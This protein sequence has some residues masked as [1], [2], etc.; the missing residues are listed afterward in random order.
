MC[1]PDAAWQI[2]P[3]FGLGIV[4]LFWMVEAIDILIVND[5]VE[6][7]CMAYLQILGYPI[8][9]LLRSLII[10]NLQLFLSAIISP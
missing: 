1:Y 2:C 7:R 4:I 8:K 5:F 10:K 3:F 6:T 9:I